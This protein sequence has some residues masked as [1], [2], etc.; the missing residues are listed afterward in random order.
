MEQKHNCSHP[1]YRYRGEP[2]PE[3]IAFDSQLQQ[4]AQQVQIIASLH[5]GGRL[6]TQE[7]YQSI[8]RSWKQ[9]KATG[10]ELGIGNSH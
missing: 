1:R 3:N 9:V 10:Q 4:F 2:T 6:S 5:T 8:K 7:S